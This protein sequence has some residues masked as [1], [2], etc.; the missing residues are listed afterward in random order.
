MAV[1]YSREKGARTC[2]R[3]GA[4]VR[5]T[6]KFCHVCGQ[7][8]QGFRD[9]KE[10]T[11]IGNYIVLRFLG[12]GGIGAVYLS[13]HRLLKQWV[14]VKVH[15]YFPRDQYVGRA[16][17]RSSNYLSQL[18]HPH[19]VHLYDY[20]F[21]DEKAYQAIEYVSGPTFAKLLPPQQ[22]KSWIDRCLEYFAQ[23]LAALHYSHLCRY[24][25]IDGTLRQ[26][27][28][29]GDIKPHNIFLD[30]KTDT[31]KLTDFMIPDV[32][33]FLGEKN[34][35]FQALD[36]ATGVVV[37]PTEAFGT[38][39]YMAPEQAEWRVTPQTDIFSLGVTMYQLVTGYSPTSSIRARLWSGVPPS[40][41][42]PYIPGWLDKLI[43]KAVQREPSQRFQ[44]VAEMIRIF[45][46]NR[47]KQGSYVSIHV[48]SISHV[49]GQL[50]I[51]QFNNVVATLNSTNQTELAGTL[52]LLKE[53]IMASQ[54]VSYHKKQELVEIINQIG[55]EATKAVPNTTLLRIVSDGLLATLR[56]IPD[57]SL[58]SA[59]GAVAP[60]LARLYKEQKK[61]SR[62]I[63][64][65]F[66][67]A[68]PKDT[69]ALRLDEEMRS[70]DVAL[71]QAEFRDRFDIKQQWA[72]RVADLQGYLL[73]H[74]PELVH[75]SGHGSA[76]SQIILEDNS[77]NSHP[78]S[79]RALSQVFSVLKDNIRCVILNA[80]YSEQQ[81]QAIAQHTDCV[82][83][84]SKAIGDA[85]A[86]SFAAA[87]YQAL[88]YGRNVKTAFDLG[89][90]QI[91][92]ENLDEQDTPK[93]LAIACNPASIIFVDDNP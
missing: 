61:M 54:G 24:I 26:G 13:R 71:R 78:V 51:G 56:T 74:K 10:G 77:G 50:F 36:Y 43:L 21:Q 8:L 32:Q 89:C 75:F 49:S 53:T 84:M 93:L 87:F 76:S 64:I 83:G 48:G 82:I 9:L 52:K 39:A 11:Q 31:I 67:A 88:G 25:D 65:L 40:H 28:F 45:Q 58:S 34:P 19:V 55:K 33:A 72:V 85:A 70:I 38:P 90:A 46:E 60:M 59:A 27:I 66:L 30:S 81:A 86:I 80:C 7:K 18:D 5:G 42:N 3:C 22:T 37:T 68:N 12:S 4:S 79:P 92:L 29:H 20:G 57:A 1:T 35:N 41:D 23:M 17:L 47:E 44:T 6:A 62:T 91:D 16:F 14:A 63:S 73:R 69:P 15:D 2:S